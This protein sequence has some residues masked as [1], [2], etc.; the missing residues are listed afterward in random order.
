MIWKL[1]YPFVQENCNNQM[2]GIAPCCINPFSLIQYLQFESKDRIFMVNG[3]GI[4]AI[5]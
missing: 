4:C 5:V 3:Q 2:Q 1:K